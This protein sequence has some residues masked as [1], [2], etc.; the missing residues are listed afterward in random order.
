MYR[1]AQRAHNLVQKIR[2][3][4]DSEA[5]AI[6]FTNLE[7]MVRRQTK[8]SHTGQQAIS[9]PLRRLIIASLSSRK[10]VLTILVTE[11]SDL[12]ILYKKT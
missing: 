3:A 6:R 4:D 10:S 2:N 9:I 12:L 7:H 1:V 11:K 8:R 5:V